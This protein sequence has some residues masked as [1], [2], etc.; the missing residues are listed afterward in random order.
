MLLI[1]RLTLGTLLSLAIA[2]A[3][4]A[5]SDDTER[6]SSG[7]AGKGAVSQSEVPSGCDGP[8]DETVATR[9][10]DAVR[11]LFEGPNAAQREVVEGILT[12]ERIAVVRGRVLN[13]DGSPLS[14]VRVSVLGGPEYG[15]TDSRGEGSY[16]LAVNGGGVVTLR[17]EL[18]DH[19]TVQRQLRV[20]WRK[21]AVFPDVVLLSAGASQ[22]VSM[23]S[24]F[25]PT[26]IEG[27]RSADDSGSRQQVLLMRPETQ[28][29]LKFADGREQSLDNFDIQTTEYTVGERGP[30]AMPG[31]LPA[32]SAYTYAIDFTVPQA[33]D[34]GAKSVTFSPPLASYVDNFL[35][36]PAGTI[37]PSGSYDEESNTWVPDQSGLV[38]AIVSEEAGLAALDID[39]DGKA[40]DTKA[41]ER[42]GIDDAERQALA[43]RYEPGQSLWRAPIEHFS[44][45]DLN[46]PFGP[47]PDAAAAAPTASSDTPS[48]GCEPTASGSIIGCESQSLGEAFR[49]DGT[50]YTLHYQ[51]E[52]MPGRSD[53]NEIELTLSGDSVSQSLKRIDLEVE[54]LGR[55]YK[56]S[57]EP[58]PNQKTTW[59][60]DGLD[61][62]GRR[63]QGLQDFEVRVGFV[64]DGVYQQTQRFGN[65][66]GGVTLTGSR[67]R[68][69]IGLWSTRRGQIGQFRQLGTGL[70]GL[71]LDVHHVYD[72]NSRTLFRGDGKTLRADALGHT[73]ELAA[74]SSTPGFAGDGEDVRRARFKGPSALS[75]APDGTVYIADTDNHR[76]RRILPSGVIDTYAGMGGMAT[77]GDGGPA[78][79]AAVERPA[80][81]ALGRDGTLYIAQ[82]TGR[83]RSVSPDGTIQTITGA[84]NSDEDGIPA[85]E[86]KFHGAAGLALAS[87]G[88]LYVAEPSA[89]GRV[90]RIGP[91]GRVTTI[92]GGGLSRE[93][94][95]PATTARFSLPWA[96]AVGSDNSLYITDYYGDRVVRVDSSGMLTL[97]AGTGEPGFSGDGQPAT[98]AKL[99]FPSGV[100]V[101]TDGSVY[102]AD[103]GN[104]RVRRVTPGGGE[105]QVPEQAGSLASALGVKL[106]GC[107]GV[108]VHHDES[109]WVVESGYPRV[110]RVRPA[111]PGFSDGDTLI[112]S[113]DGT[114]AYRFDK[115]GRHLQ[116]LDTLLGIPL[117]SFE[118]DDVGRLTSVIEREGQR[119]QIA[120]SASGAPTEIVG[121]YGH[122]TGLESDKSGLL[123]ALKRPN[124]D[125][126]RL[127]YDTGGLLTSV[128]RPGEKTPDMT[129]FE[130]DAQGRLVRDIHPSGLEQTLTREVIPDG[131][132]VTRTLN[133]ERTE[134]YERTQTMDGAVARKHTDAQGFTTESVHRSDQTQVTTQL[135]TLKATHQGDQRFGMTSSWDDTSE[136]VDG[137]VD[138]RT[139]RTRTLILRDPNNSLDVASLSETQTINGRKYAADWDGA[140][141]SG[142]SIRQRAGRRGQH[143]TSAGVWFQRSSWV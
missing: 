54:V 30:Q 119:T 41:L 114:Q 76:V 135:R 131:V 27:P 84:G 52:R 100:D 58:K 95:V 90:R 31:D 137:S 134:T 81:L 93:N 28:T 3:G 111:L 8:L 25:A 51:S 19:L 107:S 82:L 26:W 64:Y 62:Y 55:V 129:R 65:P 117:R 101:G 139:Q 7:E 10:Y 110:L 43:A 21:F 45:W 9:F 80:G 116:T 68:S 125:Q 91:D 32:T 60:W 127:T 59:Q 96:L 5:N 44:S 83:V 56:Q 92:A 115:Y 133:G 17:Y 132:R 13:P 47:P 12:E 34:A 98:A 72:P 48:D 86:A 15:Y 94:Y 109:V 73:I 61:A 74:G 123:T 140:R 104:H 138:T 124:G 35:H 36:F 70:G 78:A 128:E 18:K 85:L 4:C 71:S 16:D 130:Y 122:H 2:F 50:P 69:E 105:A 77:L 89:L 39:G 99:N 37:V 29:T 20:P 33:K 103:H 22:H 106:L 40:D 97:V 38:V 57:F 46:W 121:P 108:Y 79:Q 24:M 143:S 49:I 14:G 142:S 23:R 113:P 141:A 67:A 126:T 42:L 53:T 6:K 120:R 136:A 66:G 102:I 118:Y 87:D 1:D 75:I 63:H 88:G 11:C 112:G